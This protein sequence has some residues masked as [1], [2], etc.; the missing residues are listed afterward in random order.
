VSKSEGGVGGLLADVA[1]KLEL[2]DDDAPSSNSWSQFC[3]L[4]I[5]CSLSCLGDEAILGFRVVK[6][7]KIGCAM[8]NSSRTTGKGLGQ[9]GWLASVPDKCQ[10]CSRQPGVAG[11]H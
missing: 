6:I 9:A 11:S 10:R 8:G 4:Y 7:V 3:T 2:E 1:E 5:A